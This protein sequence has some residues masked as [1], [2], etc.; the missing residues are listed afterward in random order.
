[1]HKNDGLNTYCKQ[2]SL[3]RFHEWR[4]ANPAP[5]KDR[6]IKKRP[7]GW[8]LKPCDHCGVPYSFNAL[9]AHMPRCPKNPKPYPMKLGHRV[10]PEN[11]LE[12]QQEALAINGNKAANLKFQYGITIQ[13]WDALYDAQEGLCAICRQ[14]RRGGNSITTLS[15]DHSHATGKIRGLL[16]HMCNVGIGH[17]NEDQ[18]LI[19][20]AIEYLGK[21]KPETE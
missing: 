12:A 10:R 3:N 5:K 7:R 16:C 17:F 18:K 20:A 4:K 1:M 21:H 14:P 13:D 19:E 6:L 8:V 9:A 11:T 2:C 15:V